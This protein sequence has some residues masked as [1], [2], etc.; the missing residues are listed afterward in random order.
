[1][2]KLGKPPAGPFADPDARSTKLE[3][4]LTTEGLESTSD[5]TRPMSGDESSLHVKGCTLAQGKGDNQDRGEANHPRA[6]VHV[7]ARSSP[8]TVRR[9]FS[10]ADYGNSTFSRRLLSFL[11]SQSWRKRTTELV[12]A[13]P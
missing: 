11:T 1:M 12:K 10:K 4:T 6:C 2:D 7:V 3:E 13:S 8:S 5:S 9:A